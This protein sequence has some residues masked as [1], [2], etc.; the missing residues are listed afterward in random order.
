[1]NEPT[2]I[3]QLEEIRES[4]RDDNIEE[5]VFNKYNKVLSISKMKIYFEEGNSLL[6]VIK[7]LSLMKDLEESKSRIKYKGMLMATITHDMRTPANS[8][9]GMLELIEQYLPPEKHKYLK[10][11]HSSCNLLLHLIHDVL[12]LYIYIYIYLYIYLYIYVYRII[13]K[14]IIIKSG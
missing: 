13:Q 5:T 1:M 9:L 12:V 10:I 14:L 8:I 2:P 11:A 6:I 4:N 3:S 7:D